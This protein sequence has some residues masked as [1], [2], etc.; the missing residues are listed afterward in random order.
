MSDERTTGLIA[1]PHV[2]DCAVHNGPALEPGQC[3]CGA[4]KRLARAGRHLR[5]VPKDSDTR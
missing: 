3:D 5:E 2:S 4:V 1:V